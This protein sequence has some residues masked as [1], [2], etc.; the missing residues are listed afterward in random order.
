MTSPKLRGG[1]PA[2]R[3][4][5]A[6]FVVVALFVVLAAAQ[7]VYV[8]EVESDVEITEDVPHVPGIPWRFGEQLLVVWVPRDAA[9]GIILFTNEAAPIPLYDRR[10]FLLVV[11]ADAR[12]SQRADAEAFLKTPDGTYPVVFRKPDAGIVDILAHSIEDALAILKQIGL[13]PEYRGKAELIAKRDPNA[14][15]EAAAPTLPRRPSV[16]STFDVYGGLYFRQTPITKTGQVIIPVHGTQSACINLPYA[17]YVGYDAK[18]FTLGTLIK[19]GTLDAD[20]IVE[21]YKIQF[22]G[23]CTFLGSQRFRLANRTRYWVSLINSTTSV[24]QLAVFVMLDVR[25]FSGQ[26]RVGVN[27]S[28]IYTRTYRYGF[29]VGEFAAR[30]AGGFVVY[31]EVRRV[32]IGPYVAYDGYVAQTASSS[33]T[34]TI[35]TEPVNGVCKD[36]RVRFTI[37]SRSPSGTYTY[38]GRHLG[39]C[40]YDVYQPNIWEPSFQTEYFYAKAFGGGLAW[41]L[42]IEYTDGSTPY[43]R[44]IYLG[45]PN[46][47]DIDVFRYW[48]WAEQ[49]KT[50]PTTIDGIWKNPFLSSAYEL[51]AAP[52]E[53]TPGPGI[54]H[55]LV[56]IRTRSAGDSE[57]IVLTI[58]GRYIYPGTNHVVYIN[59]AEIDLRMRI[60]VS[61]IDAVGE[62]YLM[63]NNQLNPITPPQWVE[64]ALRILDAVTFVQIITGFGGRVAGLLLFAAGQGLRSAGDIVR[65]EVLDS[66]TNT[67]R[68]TYQR[69]WGTNV[70]SDTIIAPLRIP[71]LS[72]RDIP[73]EL[74]ITRIC[75]DG[76]CANPNLKA[77]VQPDRGYGDTFHRL[78]KNWMFRGQVIDSRSYEP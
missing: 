53:P 21:V 49:W 62:S 11:P 57:R 64:I 73:T 2:A 27:A 12:P 66:N 29:E 69:G 18:S 38:R 63:P 42:D 28:L 71:S 58:S 33:Q 44:R 39:L 1:F 59:R 26:P 60:N 45:G 31:R 41:V 20:L 70:A 61:R 10:Y 24:D 5:G 37:N 9:P 76:F 46:L 25:S 4:V 17:A 52:T 30:A 78:V 75:L 32:V 67:A 54:Y 19:G 48:R 77:Y 47:Q 14:G 16:G 6:A 56:T 51:Y 74:E 3:W 43:V 35:A 68:I 50:T 34:L 65:A 40:I 13:Q 36:L 23:N 8:Y 15:R 22:G 7:R 55:G 72:G